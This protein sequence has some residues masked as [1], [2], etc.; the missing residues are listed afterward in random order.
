MN[1]TWTDAA[2]AEV[3]SQFEEAEPAE[4]IRWVHQEFDG[5]AMALCS[6]QDPVVPQ[7]VATSAPGLQIVFLDTQY[8]FAETLT[9][10]D[11]LATRLGIQVE[12]VRPT[13][14]ADDRWRTDPGGCCRVRKVEPFL[15][16]MEG[17]R[18]WISGLRRADS[19]GRASAPIVSVDP[20]GFIKVNPIANWTDADVDRYIK[21]QELAVHPL[22][23]QGY[24]S[25]GCWP[26]TV[27]AGGGDARSGRWPGSDKTECGLHDSPVRSRP[28][29]PAP[30]AE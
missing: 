27:P 3:S 6:F 21:E 26:C 24:S 15:H 20:N 10:R 19:P 30:A 23:E 11:E 29:P 8:H 28:S 2:L 7:L 13:A 16:A 9:Y 12:V 1:T 14:A 25:I 22:S 17:R 5:E 18:A 4:I